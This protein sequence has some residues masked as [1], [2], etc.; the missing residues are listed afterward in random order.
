M[1]GLR[2]YQVKGKLKSS[3]ELYEE[4][5]V[6]C[7]APLQRRLARVMKPTLIAF[8]SFA[9]STMARKVEREMDRMGKGD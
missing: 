9:F 7:G 1:P 2:L 4:A 8:E 3:D 6:L 5:S